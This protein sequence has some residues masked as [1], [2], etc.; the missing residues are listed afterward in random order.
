MR[1]LRILVAGL[2]GLAA[3]IAVFLAAAV[4]VVTGVVAWAVQL[5]RPDHPASAAPARTAPGAPAAR[6]EPIDV[7][8]T[9]VPTD[10]SGG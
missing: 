3:M 9:R 10:S 8:A 5:F 2:V 4:V 6:G 1:V 7:V